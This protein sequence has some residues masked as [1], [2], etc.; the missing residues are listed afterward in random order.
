LRELKNLG[1]AALLSAIFG[2]VGLWGFGHFYVGKMLREIGWLIA[3]VLLI[4]SLVLLSF[5]LELLV[6][7]RF[8]YPPFSNLTPAFGFGSIV[9]VAL[10]IALEIIDFYWQIFDAYSLAKNFN[11][12]YQENNEAPW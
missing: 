3:G 2:L 12:S 5:S 6:E 8:I 1:F 9:I 7:F 4:I 11:T 10:L